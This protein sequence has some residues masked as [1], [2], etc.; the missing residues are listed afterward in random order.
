[1][2]ADATGAILEKC[3]HLLLREDGSG[4]RIHEY[5][6]RH[7]DVDRGPDV[8][9]PCKGC[10]R[11]FFCPDPEGRAL[12]LGWRFR[13]KLTCLMH[14]SDRSLLRDLTRDLCGP[15]D[16]RDVSSKPRLNEE[17]AAVLVEVGE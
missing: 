9:S 4:G 7:A 16:L 3:G 15:G 14:V 8:D 17:E 12:Q 2:E 5:A 1:M 6:W 13:S 11:L 10:R